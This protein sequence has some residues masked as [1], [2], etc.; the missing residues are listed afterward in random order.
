MSSLLSHLENIESGLEY[1]LNEVRKAKKQ[2]MAKEQV[3]TRS[4]SRKKT[5]VTLSVWAKKQK[6]FK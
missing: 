2:L 6:Q 1:Q 5:S 4:A 3:S